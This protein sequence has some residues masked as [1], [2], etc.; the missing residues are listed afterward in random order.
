M[1]LTRLSPPSFIATVVCR[2]K[3]I[4]AVANPGMTK[5]YNASSE[6]ELK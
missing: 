3:Q 1:N 4:G 6:N 5:R 2:L